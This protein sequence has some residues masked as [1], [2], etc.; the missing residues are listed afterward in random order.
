MAAGGGGRVE[1]PRVRVSHFPYGREGNPER[2]FGC[3]ATMPGSGPGRAAVSQVSAGTTTAY[4]VSR[5]TSV[6]SSSPGAPP[7]GGG[8]VGVGGGLVHPR[9][10]GVLPYRA[11]GGL[12]ESRCL[13][14]LPRQYRD[15]PSGVAGHHD[16]RGSVAQFAGRQGTRS[17]SGADQYPT[18]H[19]RRLPRQ[20]LGPSRPPRR[21]GS[22]P[23]LR[24]GT[25]VR[26]AV[27]PAGLAPVLLPGPTWRTPRCPA[28]HRF[29]SGP[30]R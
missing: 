5:P 9:V 25:P 21:T 13:P 16:R 3:H 27:R 28:T 1:P 6:Q 29:P 15:P 7:A 10:R 19:M 23:G 11:A 20:V 26:R 4:H 14:V 24:G 17:R 18:G 22:R 2:I 30:S 8:N 12:R